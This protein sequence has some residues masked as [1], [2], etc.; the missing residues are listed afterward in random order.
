MKYFLCLLLVGCTWFDPRNKIENYEC[1]PEQKIIVEEYITDCKKKVCS[2]MP[3]C[4]N[5]A[6]INRC[7]YI[8][9]DIN[10]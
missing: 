9:E 5:K 10:P 7:E 6:I 8:G 3:Y 2:P 4:R 1:N